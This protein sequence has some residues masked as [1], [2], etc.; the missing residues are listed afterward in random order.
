MIT[1]Q[2]EYRETTTWFARLIYVRL[3]FLSFFLFCQSA[4]FRIRQWCYTSKI[5]RIILSLMLI[6]Q[7]LQSIID[8]IELKT[9][10]T[11][12]SKA[13]QYTTWLNKDTKMLA[14]LSVHTTSGFLFAGCFFKFSTL[15]QNLFLAASSQ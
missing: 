15:I 14:S 8:N 11:T 10:H 12:Y 6:K 5:I 4:L 2:S 13:A 9:Y 3:I 1:S 7:H